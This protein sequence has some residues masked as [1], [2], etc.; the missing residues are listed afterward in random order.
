M[1]KI[2]LAIGLCIMLL[3]M[4]TATSISITKNTPKIVDSNALSSDQEDA[5]RWAAGNFTGTWAYDLLGMGVPYPPLGDLSGFYTMGYHWS[6]RVGRFLINFSRFN[7][8][9]A[10]T[11]EGIFFGPYLF[12]Q[13]WTNND[14]TNK[15]SFVGI[16]QYN[17]SSSEFVWR[18]MAFKGSTFY[19][20]GYSAK[21]E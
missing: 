21:F 6:V 15:T 16:G 2:L 14:D 13:Y 18:L 3:G 5:P 17:E 11:L 1:K 7:G 10:A 9:N 19:M 12:G 8:D 4:S 20:W